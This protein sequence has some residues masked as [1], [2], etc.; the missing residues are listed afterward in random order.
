VSVV[1]VADPA[2]DRAAALAATVGAQAF[3]DAP[4]LIDGL[5]GVDGLD[6]LYVCTPP[7]ARGEPDGAEALAAELGLPLFVEKPLAADLPTAEAVAEL[8][9]EAG[10]PTGTGYHW[11]HLDT[12]GHARAALEGAGGPPGLV[13]GR[14]V[15]ML[16]PPAWWS[17]RDGSGGQVVEQ[18]THLID[19]ARVLVGEVASVFAVGARV[20]LI[21]PEGDVDEATAAVLRFAGGAVGSLAATCLAD[22]TRETT[23]EIVAAG[24]TVALSETELAIH[25]AGGT[26][27]LAPTVDARVEVDREFVAVVRGEVPFATVPYAEA[28]HTHRVACAVAASA[29]AG[30]VVALSPI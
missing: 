29:L 9:A 27:R 14:W 23:L 3:A 15:G 7:F 1:G 8:V 5:G 30:E 19:L 6:A 24:V 21:G 18:A 13:V 2:G 4:A 12:L 20:G 16:P 11:R 10:I 26:R 28:L 17:R 22:R 25:D